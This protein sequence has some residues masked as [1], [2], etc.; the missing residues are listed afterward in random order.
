[1]ERLLPGSRPGCAADASPGE[2]TTP[3]VRV[4][5][6]LCR[7]TPAPRVVLISFGYLHDHRHGGPPDAE[8][9]VD[10]R[11]RFRDPHAVAGLR[12]LDATDTR[13]RQAVLSTLG[14]AVFAEN[15]ART[16]ADL[17]AAPSA[18]PVTI[19]IGCAGGRHRSAVIADTVAGLLNHRAI[20]AQ[21][22][23]RDLAEPV[24]ER[25]ADAPEGGE[26][27]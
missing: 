12:Y 15:L 24:V 4:P 16:A 25:D 21:V 11:K 14:A 23:H 9:I 8:F 27:R 3:T 10:V 20:P 6:T 5:A 17:L 7:A 26:G 22:I 19:A 1:M 2:D 13:V 18:D